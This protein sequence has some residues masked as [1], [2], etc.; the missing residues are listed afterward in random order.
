VKKEVAVGLIVTVVGGILVYWFTQGIQD[1]RKHTREANDAAAAAAAEEAR[2]PRMSEPELNI[3]RNGGDYK[4][5][6]AV[7]I[8][9]CLQ[10]CE[11]ED[12]CKA[13]TFDKSSRQCWM[14]KSV[15]LRIDN[16]RYISA[17]KVGA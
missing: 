1:E 10:A 8:D 12:E 11:R 5:F 13:I 6:V 16:P 2:R 14:K 15:P 3:D 9:A 7:D 4:D 17:V